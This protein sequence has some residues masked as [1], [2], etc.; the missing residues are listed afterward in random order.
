MASGSSCP[1]RSS[2]ICTPGAPDRIS[3]TSAS[4]IGRS[5]SKVMASQ[6]AR[7]TGTRTQVTAD[8]DALVLENLAGLAHDLGLL[9]VVAGF[10]IDGGVVAEQ[11]EGERV[12]HHLLLEGLAIEMRAGRVRPTRPSR[13]LRHR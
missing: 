3:R 10:G 12:R 8:R 2:T 1:A 9:V 5:H 13:Q 6:W 4:E 11:I 7:S